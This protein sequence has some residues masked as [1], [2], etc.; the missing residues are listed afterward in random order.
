MLELNNNANHKNLIKDGDEST[1]G[2]DVIEASQ[3]VPVIVDFWAPWCGPCKALSPILEQISN[4]RDIVIA[5]VNTDSDSKNAAK[6]GV[7][8]IPAMFLFK[9]GKMI[10]NKTGMMPK[11]Q[12]LG[13]LDQHIT[14]DDF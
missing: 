11:S 1:F 7:R 4:E 2:A 14:A 6:Y 3:E 8:G 5:K 10:D 12:L 9:D 13:W